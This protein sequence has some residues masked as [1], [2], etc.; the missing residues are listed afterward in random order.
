VLLR[1]EWWIPVEWIGVA[2]RVMSP[3]RGF[4]MLIGDTQGCVALLLTLGF[5]S[6]PPWGWGACGFVAGRT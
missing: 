6:V 5:I 4:V 1:G 3:L 2:F